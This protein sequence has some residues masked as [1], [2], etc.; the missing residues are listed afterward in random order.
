MLFT[1]LDVYMIQLGHC[2]N[3]ELV[4]VSPEWSLRICISDKPLCDTEAAGTP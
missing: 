1:K 4:S 2:S 3:K